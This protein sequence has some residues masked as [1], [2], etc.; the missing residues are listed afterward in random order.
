MYNGE[1]LVVTPVVVSVLWPSW[2]PSTYRA[3][4]LPLFT[5]AT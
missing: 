1:L 5:K 2:A 3:S 4:V